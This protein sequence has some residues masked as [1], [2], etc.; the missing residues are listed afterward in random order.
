MHNI[1]SIFYFTFTFSILVILRILIK[2][3]SSLLQK[4]PKPIVL[5]NRELILIGLSISYFFTYLN[6]N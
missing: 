5:S 1:D 6:Y 2:F 3:L 4:E